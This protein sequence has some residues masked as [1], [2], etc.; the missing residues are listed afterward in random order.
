M[1]N[2]PNMVMVEFGEEKMHLFII[3]CYPVMTV[4]I[5]GLIIAGYIRRNIPNRNSGGKLISET[6]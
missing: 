4:E 6:M 2:N 1:T 5:L 3:I